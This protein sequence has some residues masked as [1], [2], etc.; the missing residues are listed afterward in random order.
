MGHGITHEL[1]GIL[2]RRR[3]EVL[4][5]T[6]AVIPTKKVTAGELSS[7]RFVNRLLTARKPGIYDPDL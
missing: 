6:P 4:M 5:E 7:V 3:F 2:L 1:T